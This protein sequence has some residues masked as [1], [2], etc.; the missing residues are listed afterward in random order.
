MNNSVSPKVVAGAGGVGVSTPFS[1]L[2]VW[3]LGVFNI[4]VPPEVAVAIGTLVGALASLVSGY[5]VHDTSRVGTLT[6]GVSMTTQELNQAE[7]ERNR[8]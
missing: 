3:V 6:P 5:V 2:V 4:N 7:L 8:L 1:I